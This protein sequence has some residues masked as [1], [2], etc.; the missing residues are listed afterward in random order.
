[1]F[2][3]FIVGLAM[4]VY[5]NVQRREQR[6]CEGPKPMAGKIVVVGSSNTDMILQMDRIPRP[7][8]TILGGAV[9]MAAGGKGAN[10]AV[11][12]ARAGGSV[13]FLA[14]VGDDMFGRQAID[15]FRPRWHRRRPRD[16]RPGSALGRGPDLRRRGRR[17]QHRRR[18]RR[19]RPA[20]AGRC[21]AG[22]ET[23][24]A[25]D[26]LVMQLETPL[27]TVQ[28]AAELAAAEVCRSS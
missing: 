16:P 26:V 7:G 1:M 15:G 13:T 23:I 3:L 6:I 14:R 19:Q 24:A 9:R 10:Q 21:R 11:A 20:D 12:A 27:E 25:A 2:A 18:L 28:A 8:E 5:A 22:A 17:E 4:I